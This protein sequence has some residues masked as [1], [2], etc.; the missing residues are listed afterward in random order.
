MTNY[1]ILTESFITAEEID[2]INANRVKLECGHEARFMY[3]GN[4]GAACSMCE[5]LASA[6]RE[7]KLAEKLAAAEI[8]LIIA[9]ELKK[10]KG[11]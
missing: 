11:E 8:D 1:K 9:K 10:T 6:E 5:L 7:V 4:N 3:Q 2:L